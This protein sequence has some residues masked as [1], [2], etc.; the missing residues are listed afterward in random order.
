MDWVS[1]G[2]SF[3]D[4][5]I[6]GKENC[7]DSLTWQG[8]T[9]TEAELCSLEF[10]LDVHPDYTEEI[11]KGYPSDPELSH[12][13]RRLSALKDDVFHD[14]YFWDETKERLYLTETSPAQLCIPKGPIRLKL[15]QENH[16]CAFSGHQGRDRTFWN[17][18]L[19]RHFYWPGMGKSVKECVKSCESCQRSKSGKLKVGLLQ[20]LPIPERL[21]DSISMDFIVGL[22]RTDRTHDAI[23]TFVDRL[24]KYVHLVP[25]TSSIDAQSAARLYIDHVSASHGLSKTIVSD[26]DPHFT[27]AFFNLL[28][29][30][31]SETY[32]AELKVQFF[33]FGKLIWNLSHVIGR[34]KDMQNPNF[35][36]KSRTL[37]KLW[38]IVDRVFS[39][40]L[41]ICMISFTVDINLLSF[42]CVKKSYD[43]YITKTLL[44]G[45]FVW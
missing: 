3:L 17:R 27:S 40:Q 32:A 30:E 44:V 1:G 4:H 23:F 33:K 6:P 11:S 13:L 10:S 24:S 15:L 14:C 9:T 36:G 18:D 28:S 16:D 5:H 20:P 37:T 42:W 25:T 41:R 7:A 43:K 8:E 31:P 19:S 35:H 39:T 45:Y 21:W 34:Y 12:I 22:P 26:R 2:L 38:G 29:P